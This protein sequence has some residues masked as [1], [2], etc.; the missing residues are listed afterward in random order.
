MTTFTPALKA[1]AVLALGI[2]LA[3]TAMPASALAQAPGTGFATAYSA[4]AGK[5]V[6]IE[7]DVLEV[8]DNKK[9]AVFKGNVSATQ[10]DMNLKSKELYVTYTQSGN[11]TANPADGAGKTATEGANKPP[12]EGAGKT[13]TA[14]NAAASPFGSNDITQLDA[15]GNVFVT[16]KPKDETQKLQQAKGDWALFEVKKQLITMGGD[17]VLWQGD[18]VIRGSKLVVDLTTSISRFE[19][20][21]KAG[22]TGRMQATFT[23][24]PKDANKEKD[25]DKDKEEKDKEKD[26]GKEATN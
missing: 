19:N 18:N 22:G 24:P 20:P 2:L 14:A 10:G 5:P 16:M 13:A 7:A 11:K 23:P 21:G 3:K 15:K 9:V 26:K 6:D 12:A 4:N 25:K 8:D 17:V 1:S